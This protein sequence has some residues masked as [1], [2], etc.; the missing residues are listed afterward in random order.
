MV[1]T[2]IPPLPQQRAYRTSLAVSEKR[3]ARHKSCNAVKSVL[4]HDILLR[5]HQQEESDPRI[6]PKLHHI[7]ARPVDTI[8]ALFQDHEHISCQRTR[9]LFVSV[10]DEP[11]ETLLART[12]GSLFEL[13]REDRRFCLSI[14]GLCC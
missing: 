4:E 9:G 10:L 1:E 3:I 8:R 11:I 7:I 13:E 6:H 14:A 12:N 5:I 2:L